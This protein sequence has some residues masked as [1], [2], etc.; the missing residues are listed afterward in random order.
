VPR[1]NNLA[2]PSPRLCAQSTKED[3]FSPA[4]SLKKLLD[5]LRLN[6]PKKAEGERQAL[7]IVPSRTRDYQ[8]QGKRP[9]ASPWL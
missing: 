7:N 9:F 8:T 3:N 2:F 4:C 6:S 5:L 1:A